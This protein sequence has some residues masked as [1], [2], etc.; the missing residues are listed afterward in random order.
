MTNLRQGSKALRFLRKVEN[1]LFCFD[2]RMVNDKSLYLALLNLNLYYLLLTLIKKI[3]YQDTKGN[4]NTKSLVY[5]SLVHLILEYSNVLDWVQNKAAKFA[6]HRNDSNWETLAQHR[7][8]AHIYPL[9][10]AYMGEQAWK[11][12]GNRLQRP[13]YLSR[14][15]HDKKN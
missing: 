1:I 15:N 5:T 2:I 3:P 4:I 8:I 14:V 6:H 13:C 10:K 12:V 9:F 11:A 7:K